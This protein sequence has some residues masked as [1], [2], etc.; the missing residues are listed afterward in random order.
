MIT[1]LVGGAVRDKILGFPYHERDW[2][3][4]GSSAEAL[5]SEGYVPVGKD[6]P[7][8]LHPTTKEEYALARTER[9]SGMGYK[10]FNCYAEPDVTL[11]EDLLR[12]DLTI[13][14]IAEGPDGE[15]IDPYN[16]KSDLQNRIL[17]H[18]SDA[19]TEDPLRVLR[20]ARFLA[21][22]AHLGFTIADETIKL[23]QAISK[24]GELQTLPAERLWKELE[25]VLQTR[26]PECFFSA[27]D[28]MGASD[29]LLPELVN[30]NE[31]TVSVVQKSV[32]F[33]LPPQVRF[34]LLFIDK[35]PNETVALCVR[36]KC[37]NE[38]RE[39]AN[40]VCKYAPLFS[41]T[42]DAE[43]TLVLL[44]KLDAFRKEPRFK[45]YLICC[46][47]IYNTPKSGEQLLE[48]LA[49]CKSVD[50]S[51]F[52]AQGLKGKDIAIALREKRL[53]TL[54]DLKRK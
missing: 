29:V 53:Q 23:A 27:M 36:I 11:E 44:E 28:K 42:L 38:Y 2:V 52:A 19:F 18:V 43:S 48:A 54:T 21:R 14:A 45:H 25:K 30:L 3:V 22:Y 32:A 9:K 4:V 15:I 46:E 7:V 33:A 35:S 1:Y 16:G 8:F 39:L 41:A 20:L 12:R 51:I 13:N 6:F 26:S 47:L 10:G 40:V 24:S 17:R 31:H 5:L 49:V 50:A 37:P 34:A